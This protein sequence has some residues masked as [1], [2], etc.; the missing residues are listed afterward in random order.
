MKRLYCYSY[1]KTYD[2][3]IGNEKE[4]T[5]IININMVVICPPLQML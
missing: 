1:M 4:Q 2:I 5:Y 3:Q